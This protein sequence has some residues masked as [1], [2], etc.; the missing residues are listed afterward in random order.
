MATFSAI[1]L[2][3]HGDYQQ[4]ADVP[5]ALLPYPL[6]SAGKQQ[7]LACAQRLKQFAASQQLTFNPVID[8]SRQLRAYQT[9]TNIIAGL[10]LDLATCEFEA[11]AERS[12]G[13][14]ANLSLKQIEAI[15]DADPRYGALPSGWKASSDYCLPYQ[16]AESLRQ[17]GERVAQ[18]I[19]SAWQALPSR[20]LKL[21]V[22]HGA[23]IRHAAAR[24]G[25]IH[26]A[27]ISSLSMFHARPVYIQ[28]DDAGH[29]RQVG[30]DWKKRQR[31]GDEFGE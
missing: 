30:G 9:A 22:G 18:H 8:C 12:V 10:G 14:M 13:A 2:I 1:A 4:P 11:L 16:G 31:A 25:V 7:A 20:Q 24:L 27:D 21:I 28:Q 26:E 3:R 29:W 23:A 19:E 15:I 6:T 5:S 17:A